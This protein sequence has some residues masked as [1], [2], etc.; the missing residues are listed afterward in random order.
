MR[1]A[2]LYATKYGHAARVALHI[3][4][5]AAGGGAAGMLY[6]LRRLPRD[7][8]LASHDAAIVIGGIHFGRYLR[9]LEKF[10]ARNVTAL[11]KIPTAFVSISGSAITEEGRP[12]AAECIQKMVVR[13]GWDPDVRGNFGG[14]VNYTRYG[15]V[16]RLLMKRI[17]RQHGRSTDVTRDHDYTDWAAVDAF[18]RDFLRSIEDFSSS[19]ALAA[20]MA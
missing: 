19:P 9:Q 2:I 10:V 17:S 18:V 14:A 16:V 6:D 5:S 13:T 1:I 12:L 4:A 11:S 15:F 3:G 7:F 8:D 20:A